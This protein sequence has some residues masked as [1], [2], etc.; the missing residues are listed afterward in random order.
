MEKIRKSN[1][2][3]EYWKTVKSVTLTAE[4]EDL[5]L[6]EKG[7]IVTDDNEIANIM[8]PFFKEKVED[9]ESKIPRVNIS[10]TSKLEESL[11]DK[12]LNFS[13]KTVTE[14]QVKKAIRSLKNKSSS[15]VDFISPKIVKLAADIIAIPLT[16]VINSSISQGEFP[17]SWKWAKVIPV[18]KKKGSKFEKKNYR[19]VSLLKSSSKVLEI[20]INQQ[21]LQYAETSGILPK[22]QFGF[23]ARRS[24]SNAIATMHDMWLRNWR[25][26]KSQTLTCFDLSSAFDTLSSEIF[27][28]K[29][30]IYGFDQKSRNFFTSYL[31]ER[32]QVVIVGA[33]ISKPVTTSIG[34]PQGAV[35]STTCF[36]LL[37]A[38]IGLW[39]KSE[40][41]SYADDTCSTL[42]G[43]NLEVLIKSCEEEAQK[44][45]N[46]MSI[47]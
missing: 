24:T 12:N 14:A 47:N 46:Y 25:D 3:S 27:T 34:S 16:A 9:I 7:K 30:K 15:G 37:V 31:S 17:D 4:N 21:V 32:K 1:S 10:P 22:S 11:K 6:H 33:S 42:N 41:F 20:I 29:L 26:G 36:I 35:L 45:I 18:Y 43:G 13:L 23:R 5:V 38:D 28:S 44:I 40:V 39:T 19:P 2:P 8:C